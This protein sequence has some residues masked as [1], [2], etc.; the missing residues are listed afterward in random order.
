MSTKQKWL[1]SLHKSERDAQKAAT[2]LSFCRR[3]TPLLVS[4]VTMDGPDDH[5]KK[6]KKPKRLLVSVQ[7]MLTI[8]H[9]IYLA[10]RPNASSIQWQSWESAGEI[11]ESDWIGLW[12]C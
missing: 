1:L 10:R 9:K 8:M 7:H 11:H 2:T 6:K 5:E 12:G 4:A 3:H